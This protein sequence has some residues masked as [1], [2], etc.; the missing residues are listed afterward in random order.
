MIIPLF[1]IFIDEI[2]SVYVKIIIFSILNSSTPLSFL[3]KYIDG[4]FKDFMS[5]CQIGKKKIQNIGN[6]ALNL[7]KNLS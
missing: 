3:K 2:T 7:K 1:L 5:D 6:L 4:F